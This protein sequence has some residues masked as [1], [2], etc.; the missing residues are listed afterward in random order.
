MKKINNSELMNTYINKYNIN[1]I[2]TSDMREYMELFHF[3]RNEFLCKEDEPIDYL[4]F[5]V[6]GKAKVYISLKNGKSLLICF[7]YPLMVLGDLELINFTKATTNMEV[8]E[9]AY[10]IGL[11]FKKVREK[12]LNNP[13]IREYIDKD[14]E[15]LNTIINK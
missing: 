14:E 2:F 12:L 7:Y 13:E 4:F 1:D 11:S 3:K 15:I 9:D 8:I 5:F 10:C 6:E